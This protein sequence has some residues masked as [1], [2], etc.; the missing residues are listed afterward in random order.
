MKDE[1]DIPYGHVRIKCRMCGE[2]YCITTKELKRKTD[3]F[4]G[5]YPC[6]KCGS[7]STNWEFRKTN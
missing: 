4:D 3:E 6:R 7:H 1:D 5:F 2:T